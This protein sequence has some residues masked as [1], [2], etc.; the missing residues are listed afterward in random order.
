MAQEQTSPSGPDLTKGV[1]FAQFAEDKLLGHVGEEEVLL[2]RHGDEVFAVGAHCSHYHGPLAEGLVVGESVRCP[3]HHACF[4][5]RTGE[6]VRAP[7]L[8]PIDCWTVERSGDR[9]TVKE[10][11]AQPK[12]CGKTPTAGATNKIIILGGCAG[13]FTAAEMLRRREFRGDIVML[14][15]DGAAPVDR[16]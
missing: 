6:A 1:T 15:S 7:A 12:S 16:P 4:D 8:S 2:V 10:K 14:S 13:G 11:Q 5:L 9:I 3:W